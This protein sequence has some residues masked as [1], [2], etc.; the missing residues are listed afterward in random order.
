MGVGRKKPM[1]EPLWVSTEELPR[2]RGHVFY[3]RES[4]LRSFRLN[5]PA[6][7]SLTNEAEWFAESFQ[8]FVRSPSALE[9]VAPDTYELMRR[10]A[11]GDVL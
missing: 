11:R 7:Y 2:R 8:L 4:H 6:L 5:V 1:Q 9:R 10:V 3:D